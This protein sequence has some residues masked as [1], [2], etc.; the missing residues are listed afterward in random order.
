MARNGQH[1]NEYKAHSVEVVST[2]DE[3]S[4]F[5]FKAG[6]GY[7]KR[8]VEE[9]RARSL[10]VLDE[11][12]RTNITL[13]TRLAMSASTSAATPVLGPDEQD[14]LDRYRRMAPADRWDL[15]MRL[16][17]KP[18]EAPPRLS[19]LASEI[20]GTQPSPPVQPEAPRS[21]F[22]DWGTP[23]PDVSSQAET[24]AVAD[25]GTDLA[26][27][28]TDWAT[29]GDLPTSM[30]P[31]PEHPSFDGESPTA[32]SL[33][34]V[35]EPDAPLIEP[36]VPTTE[37]FARD[38]AL[39]TGWVQQPDW[40]QQAEWVDEDP[41][42]PSESL[43]FESDKKVEPL[44]WPTTPT[45]QPTPSPTT[46]TPATDTWP[47]LDQ[48]VSDGSVPGSYEW[49]DAAVSRFAD[50]NVTSPEWAQAPA[51]AAYGWPA[52]PA[53]TNDWPADP[54]DS[55]PAVSDSVESL[56]ASPFDWPSAP[57]ATPIADTAISNDRP[58]ERITFEPATSPPVEPVTQSAP[59]PSPDLATTATPWASPE[60]SRLEG[61][62]PPF[63]PPASTSYDVSTPLRA[64]DVRSSTADRYSESPLSQDRLDELFNQ[65]DFGPPGS[66]LVRREDN[67]VA[68][69]YGEFAAPLH[70]GTAPEFD[71]PLPP[72]I[73]P[74][75]GWIRDAE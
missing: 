73:R 23:R 26:A 56:E 55:W 11:L 24:T 48:V 59:W 42:L 61:T 2:Y 67:A 37:P 75:E 21:P 64:D 53:A 33:A 12:L 6:K 25:W 62:L 72:P 58:D 74:W 4:A 30:L 32:F 38:L 13:E 50:T 40:L 10:T 57:A 8:S 17:G 3:L 47:V 60:P 69:A 34:A 71:Q 54:S 63:M 9:F 31:V 28:D 1:A 7:D 35:A 14:V 52:A 65:L 51:D 43:A 66:D 46:A 49:S 15:L 44:A 29:W 39:T 36:P 68:S 18:S 20:A 19:D 22:A 5:Q 41:F 16:E 27:D 70:V 45:W